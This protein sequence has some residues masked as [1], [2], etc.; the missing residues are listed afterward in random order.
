MCLLNEKLLYCISQGQKAA[1]E[2]KPGG[3]AAHAIKTIGNSNISQSKR[4]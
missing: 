1:F 2:G 3:A 4:M